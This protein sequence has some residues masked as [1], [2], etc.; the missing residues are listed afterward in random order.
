MAGKRKYVAMMQLYEMDEE[1]ME[2][3]LR[4]V[5]TSITQKYKKCWWVH[6]VNA[7]RK[8]YGSYH[9]LVQEL[10]LDDECY[11]KYLRLN[12]EQFNDVL[13]FV[14]PLIHKETTNYREAIS[15]EERLTICLR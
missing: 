7:A 13:R 4:V 8:E 2:D 1:E 9:H 15:E 3:E 11:K 12:K 10:R 6:P 5:L 14:C